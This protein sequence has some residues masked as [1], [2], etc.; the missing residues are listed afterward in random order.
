MATLDTAPKAVKIPEK[1]NKR[2]PEFYLFKLTRKITYLNDGQNAHGGPFVIPSE[3]NILWAYRDQL[4]DKGEEV[5]YG[6]DE[7]VPEDHSNFQ[8]RRIRYIPNIQTIFV[9]EQKGVTE[10]VDG[11]RHA[12]LDNPGIR[13]KLTFSRG[14]IRVK[15]GEKNLFNF[16]RC[17][18]QASN[19]HPNVRSLR[20]TD[21]TFELVDFGYMDKVK[22]QKGQIKEKAWETA[23]TTRHEDMIPH[24][25]FLGIPLKDGAGIDREPEAIK[26]DYKEFALTNPDLFIS[27]FTDPTTKTL[28]Y[29]K[30]LFE[31]GDLSIDAS[32]AFWAKT[33]TFISQIPMD[34]E[35]A[36][37][38]AEFSLT[39][40][41]KQFANN[42]RGVYDDF[43]NKNK[44][45][46][47]LI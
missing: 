44:S 34:K 14:E 4:N 28:Y 3:A 17:N 29:I 42:L 47:N 26:V 35:P 38:L 15:S 36:R 21:P 32:S 31:N 16:L 12:I 24:A 41:G 20:N 30:T 23:H 27:S 19:K 1:L 25:K 39:E 6:I 40:E 8:V 11:Q 5:P 46:K 9:D 7:E 43:K 18:P 45:N 37:Y 13:D 2:L 33:K 22:V 10:R